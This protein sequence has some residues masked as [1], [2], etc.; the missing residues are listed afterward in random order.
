MKTRVCELLGIEYPIVQAAM[1][2]VTDAKMVVAVS[3]AGAIGT[4][5]P[6]AGAKTITRDVN[7]TAN[8]LREQ[9]RMVRSY[10]D[11]PFA[12][13][14][15]IGWGT[16]R[17]FGDSC[18]EVGIEEQVP[19]AIVSQ[20]GPK[21]Y[22][23]VLKRAGMK[24]LH[25]VHTVEHAR[26][27]EEAGVDAIVTSGF[28]GGGHGG[29]AELTTFA[30][31]PQI[32]DAVKIPVIAGGG[33]GDERGLV[34]ALALGAEGVYMGTRFIATKECRVHP[35]VKQALLGADEVSTVSVG[36]G[37]GRHLFLGLRTEPVGLHAE[38]EAPDSEE[39]RLEE[40]S[41]GSLRLIMCEFARQCIELE[42]KGASVE[43][44]QAFLSS[45]PP[46]REDA[47]RLLACLIY[48]DIDMGIP[49]GQ[50]VGLIKDIPSCRELVERI[51]KGADRVMGR[52]VEIRPQFST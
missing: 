6:N 30:V 45:P 52:L 8:R 44:L 14:F 41:R 34:A 4:L 21:A 15:P 17:K 29:W 11:K 46:G 43:E 32:V 23:G 26:K 18:V 48:G 5:G 36:H 12:V 35:K 24:V 2:W 49:A 39:Y 7:D 25:V 9:I 42:T 47:S 33:V 38:N 31:L 27:A 13:N 51:I 19:V 16:S 37:P 28:E 1:N 10:T 22:T 3:N 20:G 40:Q 50:E